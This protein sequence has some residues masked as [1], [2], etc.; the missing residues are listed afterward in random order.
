MF[1]T[2]EAAACEKGRGFYH[3]D[4]IAL[5]RLT[6]GKKMTSS[7]VMSYSLSQRL[8]H[9]IMAALIL[10]NLLFTE[11]MEEFTEAAEEVRLSHPT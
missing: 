9:W 11:S 6:K 10:F 7:P 2:I 3:P 1:F 5:K 4:V 8:I